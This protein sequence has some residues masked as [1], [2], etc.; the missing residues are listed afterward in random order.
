MDS[1]C[2]WFAKTPIAMKIFFGSPAVSFSH[3]RFR[4]QTSFCTEGFND[5]PQSFHAHV[6]IITYN[7]FFPR[8]F[9][10]IS[11]TLIIFSSKPRHTTLAVNS[12]ISN[13]GSARSIG[14]MSHKN[15]TIS[16]LQNFRNILSAG[17]EC[18]R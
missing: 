2:V 16:L 17:D 5:L 7:R 15:M 1:T 10:L 6:G 11:Y 9:L 12:A 18:Q 13:S 4:P 8:L 3:S 14:L